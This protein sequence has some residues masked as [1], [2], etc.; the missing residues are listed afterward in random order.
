MLAGLIVLGALALVA[1]YQG[2]SLYNGLIEIRNNVD[3]AWAN[4]DVILKQRH[5]NLGKLVEVVRGAKNFEEQTLERVVAARD[6]YERAG[7]QLQ[8]LRGAQAED[9]AQRRFLAVAEN[10]PDLKSNAS[11]TQL[12]AEAQRLDEMI[13]ARR[14]GYNASVN[15]CQTRFEQ[16][17]ANLFAGL[18]GS[19]HREY[20]RAD[21]ADRQDVAIQF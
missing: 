15:L 21:D 12:S 20:F 5:D 19:H 17:P 8:S 7:N 16:F 11:F 10:Y 14:E 9:S 18:L 4:I 1:V 3:L 6:S 2:V 13:A